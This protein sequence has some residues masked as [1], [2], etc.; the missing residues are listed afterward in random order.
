[1]V[2]K[3]LTKAILDVGCQKIADEAYPTFEKMVRKLV[4]KPI[5]DG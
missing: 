5:R 4:Q 1:M 3:L 2:R